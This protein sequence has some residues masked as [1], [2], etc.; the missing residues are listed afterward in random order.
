MEADRYMKAG[1]YDKA[2]ELLS[3]AK[4]WYCTLGILYTRSNLN[5]LR[6]R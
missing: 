2:F 6:C 1:D 5:G 4:K 3:L